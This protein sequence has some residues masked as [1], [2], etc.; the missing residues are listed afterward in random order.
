MYAT[1]TNG[2]VPLLN[3][4]SRQTLKDGPVLIL[5]SSYYY[6]IYNNVITYVQQSFSSLRYY[7]LLAFFF[8]L[9]IT[10][11]LK[12]K[13]CPKERTYLLHLYK[14]EFTFLGKSR[15]IGNVLYDVRGS[16]FN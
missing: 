11:Y 10:R 5:L 13:K 12:D 15:N 14:S 3:V 7:G 1:M 8:L 16:I 2:I 6:S 4:T 9:D